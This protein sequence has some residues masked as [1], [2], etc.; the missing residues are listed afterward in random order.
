[1]CCVAPLTLNCPKARVFVG[2]T[3]SRDVMLLQAHEHFHHVQWP[4][5]IV[6]SVLL[7]RSAE[8]YMK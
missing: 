7:Q 8:P 4:V 6:P 5:C 3:A 2:Q 1:M